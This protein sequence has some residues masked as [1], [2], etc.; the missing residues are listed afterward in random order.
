[1]SSRARVKPLA[2]SSRQRLRSSG[3]TSTVS[4][5][6]STTLSFGSSSTASLRRKS[7]STL[8]KAFCSPNASARPSSV[9]A[10][11]MTVAV[12]TM[13]LAT[14]ARLGAGPERNSSS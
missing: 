6:S 8:M 3:V 14:M 1:M 7:P 12:A 5:I 13:W 9:K 10:W 2:F 4:R 11:V